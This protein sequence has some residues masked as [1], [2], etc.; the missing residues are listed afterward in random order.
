MDVARSCCKRVKPTGNEKQGF[1]D[2]GHWEK[3]ETRE[4]INRFSQTSVVMFAKV[5]PAGELIHRRGRQDILLPICSITPSLPPRTLDISVGFTRPRN[6]PHCFLLRWRGIYRRISRGDILVMRITR[7]IKLYLCYLC[8][9]TRLSLYTLYLLS[10]LMPGIS[11][12]LL[13]NFTIE[14]EQIPYRAN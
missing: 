10:L 7:A 11:N 13:D 2:D 4:Y 3:P 5:A 1:H 6:N 9:C 12:C 8:D 14:T